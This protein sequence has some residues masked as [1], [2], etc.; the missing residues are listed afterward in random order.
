MDNIIIYCDGYRKHFKYLKNLHKKS[1]LVV[2]I[3]GDEDAK[4]YKPTT[5]F[6]ICG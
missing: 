2:G 1:T 6:Q 3:V 4:G 5:T